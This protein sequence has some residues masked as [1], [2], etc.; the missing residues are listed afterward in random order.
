MKEQE[1]A[2]LTVGELLD[3]AI[4]AEEEAA[5]RYG[6][7]AEQMEAAEKVMR[8]DRDALRKLGE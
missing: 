7:F 1:L 2:Q 3:L 5:Q 4:L 8:E 6:E